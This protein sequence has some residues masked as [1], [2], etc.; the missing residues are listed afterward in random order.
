MKK[1]SL[2]ILGFLLIVI[3]SACGAGESLDKYQVL[4]KSVEA[5]KALESYSVEMN[6]DIDMMD[7]QST[8]TATA[9]ISWGCSRILF[10]GRYEHGQ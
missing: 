9:M 7:M 8:M 3:L 4:S 2:L 6:M 5:S 1:Y 10:K